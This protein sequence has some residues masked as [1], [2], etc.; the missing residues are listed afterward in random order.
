M[1]WYWAA[2]IWRQ[3]RQIKRKL[4]FNDTSKLDSRYEN[5]EKEAGADWFKNTK[6]SREEW[7]YHIQR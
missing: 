2:D 4:S 6:K 7:K 5:L 1:F 3:N